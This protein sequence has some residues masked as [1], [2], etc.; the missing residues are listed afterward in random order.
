MEEKKFIS[1][2]FSV[3]C[4]GRDIIGSEVLIEPEEVD[5]RISQSPDC[6]TISSSVRCQYNTGGHGER[7]KASHPGVDKV[8]EGV[9]CP[10]SFDVPQ[11]FDIK[12]DDYIFNV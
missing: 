11:V 3:E 2:T 1:Q 7:C 5:V 10:Y 12:S 9:R 8:D 4:R 6:N